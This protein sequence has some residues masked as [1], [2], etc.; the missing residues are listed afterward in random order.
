METFWF[1][2]I[3]LM[4]TTYVVL[5]GFD[6][7]AGAILHRICKSNSERALVI[8]AIGPVWDGN[9]VWLVAAG[10][11]LF[12]AFPSLYA[13]SFSGFYLPLMMVLWLLMLRGIG[14]ELRN[15]VHNEMWQSLW[16]F[17][18]SL[19]S[20]LLVFMFGAALGNVIRGVQFDS[21][22]E[23]FSPLWTNLRTSGNIGILDWYTILTGLVAVVSLTIH[24]AH[25]VAARSAGSV[26]LRAKRFASLAWWPLLAVTG[27]SLAATLTVRPQIH[28]NYQQKPWLFVFPVIVL[29][30]LGLMRYFNNSQRPAA[31]WA[32]FLSSAAYLS[33]LL[34]GAAAALYPVLLPSN[35]DPTA[36]LTIYNAR[37]SEY[38]LRVGMMWWVVGIVLAIGYFIF[39]YRQVREKIRIEA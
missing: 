37:A 10:G 17:V 25:Y 6:L 14:I 31:E 3:A 35:N 18:F 11:T 2:A 1:I 34:L 28:E 32:A 15:H 13:A 27:A 22:G 24:G 29:V 21:Q 33:G 36:G 23:F 16:D 38:G 5:D 12:F 20:G 7:G 26:N 19:S 39:L 8:E 30:S 4:L 9:E